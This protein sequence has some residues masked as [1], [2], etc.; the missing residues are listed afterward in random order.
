MFDSNM[1]PPP[2][3]LG[4]DERVPVTTEYVIYKESPTQNH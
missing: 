4:P 2:L 1:H 3:L